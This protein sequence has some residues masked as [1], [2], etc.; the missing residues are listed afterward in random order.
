MHRTIR[1]VLVLSLLLL[2]G[3]GPSIRTKKLD[4]QP[5]PG[6]GQ[7]T[8]VVKAADGISQND[9]LRLRQML[10]EK[11]GLAGFRP[12]NIEDSRGSTGRV[13]EMTVTK[14]EHS[15]PAKNDG[16]FAGVGCVYLCPL[17]APC[18]LVPGYYEPQFQISAD[19]SVY[20]GNHRILRKAFQETSKSS[21]NLIN[22]GDEEF[23]TK[24]EDLTVHNLVIAILK[25]LDA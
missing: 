6:R 21:A 24:L 12:V 13:L 17:F 2:S 3:C 15:W 23:Q 20:Q 16:I 14:Y 9:M 1:L 22:T 7:M 25:E 18:L 5:K 4:L 19:V 11:F 8:I 10:V